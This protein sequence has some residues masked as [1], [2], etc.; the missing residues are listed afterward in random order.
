MGDLKQA[1]PACRDQTPAAAVSSLISVQEICDRTGI[2]A[3]RLRQLRRQLG[4]VPPS[5]PVA[6]ERRTSA[7]DLTSAEAAAKT[8]AGQPAA[9]RESTPHGRREQT[10]ALEASGKRAELVTLGEWG[11]DPMPPVLYSYKTT[12]IVDRVE[13]LGWLERVFVG[14]IQGRTRR[15][16][17]ANLLVE[18]FGGFEASKRATATS[19][20]VP[21]GTYVQQR[22]LREAREAIEKLP[23][24]VETETKQLLALRSLIAEHGER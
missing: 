22:R 5:T 2:K 3:G 6:S 13:T 15:L 9:V 10:F 11:G 8:D 1:G 12:E 19:A 17:D 21:R 14:L 7:S 4:R 18:Q 20:L 23:L 24:K 16:A